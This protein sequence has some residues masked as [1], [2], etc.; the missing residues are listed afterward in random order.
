M[1]TSNTD[2]CAGPLPVAMIFQFQTRMATHVNL[3]TTT[4]LILVETTTQINSRQEKLAAL[5]EEAQKTINNFLAQV[6]EVVNAQDLL[7]TSMMVKH[8]ETT[9][10]ELIAQTNGMM[11]P[12]GAM[13]VKNAK[14]LHLVVQELFIG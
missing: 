10:M 11:T 8:I 9:D 2:P 12:I 7:K 3:G 5:V 6:E 1:T 14:A 4:I 13:L